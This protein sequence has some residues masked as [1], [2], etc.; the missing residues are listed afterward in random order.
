MQADW[1]GV[2][3]HMKGKLGTGPRIRHRIIQERTASKPSS[4]AVFGLELA[5]YLQ[6][7]PA[8]IWVLA[9]RARGQLPAWPLRL[10]ARE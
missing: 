9:L 8:P 7:R 10:F 4:N 2:P 5:D 6:I 1:L 3:E